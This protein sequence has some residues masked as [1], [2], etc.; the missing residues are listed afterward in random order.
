M[1]KNPKNIL[2]IERWNKYGKLPFLALLFLSTVLVVYN[3]SLPKRYELKVNDISAYDIVAS[4]SVVDR[5][6]TEEAAEEAMSQVPRKLLRSEEISN[7]VN[8]KAAKWM[9]MFAEA[10]V[11]L[12]SS[13][14]I[15]SN[16]SAN[17]SKPGEHAL[18]LTEKRQPQ[19]SEVAQVATDL[20]NR[21]NTSFNTEFNI[22]YTRQ[23]LEMSEDRYNLLQGNVIDITKI[24]MQ[25]SLDDSKLKQM[26]EQ[27]I[28]RLSESQEF[29]VDDLPI[30]QLIVSSLVEVNVVYDEKATENARKDAYQRVMNNPIMIIAGT[31]LV[32]QGDVVNA[33]TYEILEQLDLITGK[34]IEWF[35]LLGVTLLVLVVFFALFCYVYLHEHEL[36]KLDKTA[37]TIFLTLFSVLLL[38]SYTS[39]TFPLSPPIYFA[40]VIMTAYFGMRTSLVFCIGLSVITLPMTFFN[41]HFLP[42]ALVGILVAT[43][44]AKDISNP[45]NYVRL[46]ASVTISN[47]IIRLTIGLILRETWLTIGTHVAVATISGAVSVLAALGM[48]PL[49]EMILNTVS[50]LRLIDLSQPSH[51]LLKRLF[52]EAPGTSQHSIMV[53]TLADAGAEAIGANSLLCRV[54]AYY[55]DIGKLENPIMFI[56]NQD[57][58][59]PHDNLTPEESA[60]VII[61]HPIDGLNIAKR[62]R[63]P[64]PILKIIEQHHGTTVLQYFYHKALE[65]A[66]AQGQPEPS[67]DKFRYHTPIP[68]NKEVGVVMFADSVE[69]AMKASGINNLR[70]AEKL[71]RNIIKMKNEQ[72][73]FLNS[74]LSYQ[75]VEQVLQAFLQ[76]YAGQFHGRIK[77]P[78]ASE[79]SVEQ[80]VD[81][82]DKSE[83]AYKVDTVKE[84]EV[85]KQQYTQQLPLRKD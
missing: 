14:K 83:S 15:N 6:Q 66:K 53:A 59:N 12:Y 74:G 5:M 75:E 50:P 33:R 85:H 20:L 44:L 68:E 11:K 18:N 36:L 71:M 26:L 80:A 17:N 52:V 63:L 27:Q 82:A 55:H 67:I 72:N 58:I 37:I 8:G 65:Q 19:A 24:M 40:A 81:R 77:Y 76:V 29:Y 16:P 31:R 47:L 21:I 62:Y 46:I 7:A 39:A 61:R 70:E 32:S 10:R 9:A 45:T 41:P 57:G 34:S 54:G 64:K 28:N 30:V 56:E 22:D 2:W 43:I 78:K 84:R 69:A 3:G 25:E 42:T 35:T 1:K 73:Q 4:R 38:S 79:D 13:G 48:M 49:F 51:P 60:A 23:V